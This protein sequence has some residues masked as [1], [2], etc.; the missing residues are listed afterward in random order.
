MSHTI[1]RAA[2]RISHAERK[3][4][5]AI[6]EQD[7]HTLY[8]LAV[9]LTADHKAAE[10]CFL[11]AF[12]DCLNGADVFPGWTRSWSRRAIVKQAIRIVKP[13]PDDSDSPF[14]TSPVD[15]QDVPD[16]LMQMRP[17]DRFVFAMTML[18]R[19]TVREA[20]A[21]LNCVPSDVE[22]ARVR[23]LRHIGTTGQDVPPVAI[24]NPI[25]PSQPAANLRATA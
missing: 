2:S 14:V 16:R 11:V 21:F 18:E 5:C 25:Q 15:T 6:F 3:D 1:A 24:S 23:V 10:Q 19:Y 9:L 7:M 8:S 13:R 20:A 17:F 12:D 4:F 22:K